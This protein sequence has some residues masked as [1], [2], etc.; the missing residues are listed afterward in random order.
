MIGWF[1]SRLL[2]PVIEQVIQKIF[3]LVKI[4][5]KTNLQNPEFRFNL[6]FS[7][8]SIN[9]ATLWHQKHECF[10]T[11]TPCQKSSHEE[12]FFAIWSLLVTYFVCCSESMHK[13]F[14]MF[15]NFGK[16]IFPVALVGCLLKM[17]N[18]QE[19]FFK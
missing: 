9:F 6:T 19:L 11:C 16:L 10:R 17:L 7:L 3:L 4:V 1:L 14:N 18:K 2:E 5:N 8:L 12:R 15:V 13:Y